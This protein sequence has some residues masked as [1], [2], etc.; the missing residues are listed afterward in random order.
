MRLQEH[1]CASL[2][3]GVRGDFLEEVMA[4]RGLE[5]EGL[6]RAVGYRPASWTDSLTSRVV[7]QRGRALKT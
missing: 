1:R 4:E 3:S 6:K 5:G 2:S 7:Y